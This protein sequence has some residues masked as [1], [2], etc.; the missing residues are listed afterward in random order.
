MT[1]TDKNKTDLERVIAFLCKELALTPEKVTLHARLR[2]DLGVDGEDAEYLL[3]GFVHLFEID[4]S[5]LRL[6][7]YFG[8]E[9]G[10][11]PVLSF[12]LW[13]FGNRK[14]LKTLRV[15]DLVRAVGSK[16]L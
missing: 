1:G 10:F 16:R 9:A 11:N 3:E 7:D 12:I 14:P 13:I 6:N 5:R 2:Q 4:D 8:P 15:A